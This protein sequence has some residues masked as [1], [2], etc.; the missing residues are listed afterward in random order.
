ME[1]LPNEEW[2]ASQSQSRKLPH[3]CPVASITGCPR[4]FA[5]VD[6]A[7]RARVLSGE[8]PVKV[9]NHLL[10]KWQCSDALVIDDSFVGTS[11]NTRGMFSG[12]S[13]FC[14]EV[15][16]SI[17]GLYCSDFRVHPDDSKRYSLL[18]PKHYTSCREYSLLGYE[19]KVLSPVERGITPEKRFTVFQRDNFKCVYCGRTAPDVLL[20]IDHKVSRAEGGGDEISNLVTACS[21][22]NNGKGS[23][24]V[25]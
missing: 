6:H 3:H 17:A 12:V 11:F 23:A 25:I 24:S 8:I 14:P 22:C 10:E 4:Y 1:S 21:V 13:N 15:S 16:G 7:Q 18:H 9:R 20:H 2:Y 19:E 5:S